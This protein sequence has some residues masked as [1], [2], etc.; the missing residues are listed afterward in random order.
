MRISNCRLTVRARELVFG[1]YWQ[2]EGQ[3]FLPKFQVTLDDLWPTFDNCGILTFDLL[4]DISASIRDTAVIIFPDMMGL[5]HSYTWPYWL[6]TYLIQSQP[7]GVEIFR[8]SN[9]GCTFEATGLI[10]GIYAQIWNK[11]LLPNFWW[12]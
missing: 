1:K 5:I 3:N 7:I 8:I 6:C 2:V 10:F 12:P 11:N 4:F 9:S